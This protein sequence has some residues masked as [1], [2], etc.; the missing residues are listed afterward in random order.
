VLRA[1]RFQSRD[2]DVG[3]A[4][5]QLV[6]ERLKHGRAGVVDLDQSVGLDHDEPDAIAATRDAVNRGAKIVG[7]EE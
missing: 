5:S 1:K 6:H 4:R 7:V 2:R 3:S